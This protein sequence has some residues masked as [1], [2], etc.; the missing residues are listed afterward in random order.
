MN[1]SANFELHLQFSFP[2]ER[3]F[4]ALT[5]LNGVRNWWTQFCEVSE[6]VG[7][8]SWIVFESRELCDRVNAAVMADSRLSEMME[9]GFQ[10]YDCKRMV[11]G[12]F[13]ALVNI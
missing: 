2:S 13:K 5:T 10:P 11:Y 4:T 3:V 8:Q 9:P 12:G 6:V 7:G 1:A